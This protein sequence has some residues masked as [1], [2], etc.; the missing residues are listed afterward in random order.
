MA[1]TALATGLVRFAI[2]RPYKALRES[3]PGF[4]ENC[5]AISK[6]NSVGIGSAPRIP[7]RIKP[8]HRELALSDF[9]TSAIVPPTPA[10]QRGGEC[11]P[12]RV[13]PTGPREITQGRGSPMSCP[14]IRR[15]LRFLAIGLVAAFLL[16]WGGILVLAPTSWARDRI[17]KRLSEKTGRTVHLD[18]VRVGVFGGVRLENLTIAEP[19]R[20]DDPWLKVGR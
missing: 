19:D 5:C 17:V 15:R 8:F 16:V 14:L 12:P 13:S 9:G 11:A 2:A 4:V 6:R 3:P 7:E 20:K 1:S 10:A 18:R